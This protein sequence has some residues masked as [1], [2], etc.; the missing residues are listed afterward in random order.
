MKEL[1]I[2]YESYTEGT[3]QSKK[4]Y[5][6]LVNNYNIGGYKPKIASKCYCNRT[7]NI[8]LIKKA[9]NG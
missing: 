8:K 2:E 3:P 9:C 6:K 4:A 1:L 7:L 5:E